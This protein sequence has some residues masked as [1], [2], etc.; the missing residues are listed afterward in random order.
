MGQ[1]SE[2][3]GFLPPWAI[4]PVVAAVIIIVGYFIA[5]IAAALISGAINRTGLETLVNLYQK[6]FFGSFG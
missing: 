3:L 5:K 2:H 1:L 6:L 4:G